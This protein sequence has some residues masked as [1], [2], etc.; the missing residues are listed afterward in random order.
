MT[1]GRDFSIRNRRLVGGAGVAELR[2]RGRESHGGH[3]GFWSVVDDAGSRF[4][5]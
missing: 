1:P 2:W 4:Q 3:G 5:R